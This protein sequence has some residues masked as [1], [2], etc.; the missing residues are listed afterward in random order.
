MDLALFTADFDNCIAHLESLCIPYEDWKDEP[1][2]VFVRKEGK[3]KVYFQ[4]PNGY[5]V[6][7]LLRNSRGRRSYDGNE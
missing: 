6:E 4:N 2:Q 3:R 5:W 7:A 1:N